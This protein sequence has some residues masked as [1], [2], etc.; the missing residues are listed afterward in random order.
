[1]TMNDC[2]RR[3]LFDPPYCES[4]RVLVDMSR[5]ESRTR[6]DEPATHC[7]TALLKYFI[8]AY[9][10]YVT[11]DADD[12]GTMQVRRRQSRPSAK[13]MTGRAESVRE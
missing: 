6:V 3:M 13:S 12:D 2:Q 9:N 10:T 5:P 7:G 1:M 8:W 4:V 11:H